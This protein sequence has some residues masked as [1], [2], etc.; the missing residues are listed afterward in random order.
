MNT[1][2]ALT[3]TLNVA[4]ASSL[5]QSPLI[6]S[7]SACVR[8]PLLLWNKA[9]DFT[10]GIYGFG[11]HRLIV[12]VEGELN[13]LANS[14]LPATHWYKAPAAPSRSAVFNDEPRRSVRL[15]IPPDTDKLLQFV[16]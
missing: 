1:L 15:L 5:N 3:A 10:V 4:P 7:R 2:S 9:S 8:C 12:L 16:L 11:K 13:V 14:E 6:D